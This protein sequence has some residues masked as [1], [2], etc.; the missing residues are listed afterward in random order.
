MANLLSAGNFQKRKCLFRFVNLRMTQNQYSRFLSLE[1]IS[2]CL[3][4][5]EIDRQNYLKWTQNGFLFLRATFII[6][7][8]TGLIKKASNLLLSFTHILKRMCFF[9]VKFLK[10]NFLKNCNFWCLLNLKIAFSGVGLRKFDCYQ[11][12]FNPNDS[13]NS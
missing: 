5:W 4:E 7:P 11:Y 1:N 8:Y 12:D 9:C 3:S 6:S 13:M 2:F 10:L